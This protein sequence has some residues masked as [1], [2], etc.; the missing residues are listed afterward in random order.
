MINIY[1]EEEET[2]EVDGKGEEVE[3]NTKSLDSLQTLMTLY[4]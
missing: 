4:S 1:I 2:D 3:P